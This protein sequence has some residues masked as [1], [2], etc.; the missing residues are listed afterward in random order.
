MS[1]L[2]I[3][4]VSERLILFFFVLHY[5]NGRISWKAFKLLQWIEKSIFFNLLKLVSFLICLEAVKCLSVV[6]AKGRG[7]VNV[8][9]STQV[10]DSS[11]ENL[12]V[13]RRRKSLSPPGLN[14][15]LLQNENLTCSKSV[16]SCAESLI[17]F[18]S[19]RGQRSFKDLL[20]W[21]RRQQ[22]LFHSLYE[23]RN[24]DSISVLIQR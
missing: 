24:L 15:P 5:R 6:W 2:W 17:W 13:F 8:L 9:S 3:A 1:C 18:S 11:I 12:G 19:W 16:I 23:Q 7:G 21:E 20:L 10:S 14:F 4:V 22:M